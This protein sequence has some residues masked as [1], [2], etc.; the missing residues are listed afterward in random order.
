L[1]PSTDEYAMTDNQ[2]QIELLQ[3]AGYR[4]SVRFDDA[5][6]PPLLTDEPPPLGANAGPNP[7]RLLGAAVANCLA[8]SLVFALRKF[9]N[10]PGP[11]RAVVTVQL[12]RNAHGRFRVPRIAVQIHLALLKNEMAHLVRALA[13]YQDFCVVTQSVRPAIEVAVEVFDRAG[14][15][16]QGEEAPAT[17]LVH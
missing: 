1:F 17:P 14:E 16:L 4:F 10:E 3:Q 5:G 13:Q 11:V 2:F 9:G 8:G 6:I 15:L 12:E 7:S